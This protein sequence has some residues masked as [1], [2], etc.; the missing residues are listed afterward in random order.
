MVWADCGRFGL[1]LG[2]RLKPR[3]ACRSRPHFARCS[4]LGSLHSPIPALSA[5]LR[6][7]LFGSHPL[8]LHGNWS[9]PGLWCSCNAPFS[10]R[11]YH[12]RKYYHLGTPYQSTTPKCGSTLICF[13]PGTETPGPRCARWTA[14]C[15]YILFNPPANSQP[16]IPRQ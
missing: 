6:I 11:V 12:S 15:R 13:T 8:I 4:S 16:S 5:T 7:P 1:L 10:A 2:G 9:N 14:Y 3:A